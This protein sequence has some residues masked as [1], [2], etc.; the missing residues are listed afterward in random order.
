[1]K[2]TYKSISLFTLAL[3]VMSGCYLKSVHP[4]IN[5]AQSQYIDG[6]DGV[7]ESNDQRWTFISN[8]EEA[9]KLLSKLDIH[10]VSFSHDDESTSYPEWNGYL[11]LFEN[12]D[13]N[14]GNRILFFGNTDVIAGNTYLNLRVVNLNVGDYS[15]F[16]N[17]R[18]NT[19]SKITPEENSLMIEFFASDWIKEQI[20]NNRLRIKH[21]VVQDEMNDNNEILITASN[22]ELR[23]FVEKYGNEEAA[24]EDPIQLTRSNESL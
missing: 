8:P 20:L 23:K 11:V 18:V 4:L 6:L 9:D 14:E 24:F 10:D 22:R 1:M 21:E 3:F 7:F 15:D 17:I 5:T 12:L 13:S 16:F 2:F 19:I